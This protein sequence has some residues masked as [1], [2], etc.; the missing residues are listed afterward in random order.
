MGS[1]SNHAPTLADVAREARVSLM[2]AS[3]VLNEAGSVRQEKVGKVRAAIARLGYRPNELARSLM[4][5]KS[6][7]IGMIVANLSNPFAVDVIKAVQEI[8]RANGY[9]VTV[10]SSASNTDLER[11]EIETLVRRQIDGLLIAPA[12]TGADTFSGALPSEIPAVTFDQMVRGA[13]FDSVT[14]TNRESAREATRHMLSHN[15]RR[16]VA[17]GTRPH[18]YT[19]KE[20]VAGYSEAMRNAQAEPRLCIVSHE[21]LLTAGWLQKYALQRH[22]ADGIF[23]LNW[24]STLHVLRGLRQLGVK[25]V[26]DIPLIAF[27]DFDL[28]DLLTPRL[29]VVKQPSEMLGR[30]S[31]RLLLKRLNGRAKEPPRA[32]VLPASLVI[33]ESCGCHG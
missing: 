33:R 7:T 22:Q 28:G 15:L 30:E 1:R 5:R 29:S 23:T 25:V 13:S 27:D 4:T 24:V 17:I 11:A 3:R 26:R 32:V 6:A 12:D 10:S 21:D 8:A 18:V 20:R 9:V 31:A 14:I 16:I 19:T 2:T